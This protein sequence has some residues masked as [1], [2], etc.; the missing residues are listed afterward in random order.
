MKQM[1]FSGTPLL[2][3]WFNRCWQFDLIPLPF[4]NPAWT[5]GSSWFTYFWSLTWRILSII[6]LAC[7]MSSVVQQFEHSLAL[8]F[9]G[10]GVKTDL[11]Q[12]HGH[13]CF[14]ECSTL[15]TSSFRILNS[16][17]RITSPPLTLLIIMFPKS[18]LTSHARMFHLDE[19]P[20]HHGCLGH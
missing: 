12:S 11:F 1:F 9:F 14:P 19:W 2:S 15:T 18:H 13:C 5:S 4:L 8:P 3:L 6:L 20:Y 16:S 10:I 17:A 7:E